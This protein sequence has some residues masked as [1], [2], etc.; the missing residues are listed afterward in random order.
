M[1]LYRRQQYDTG[2][3]LKETRLGVR[4]KNHLPLLDRSNLKNK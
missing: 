1:P 3:F 4:E 2:V